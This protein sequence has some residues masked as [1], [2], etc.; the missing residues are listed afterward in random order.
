[1]ISFIVV[2]IIKGLM[3][4]IRV[5]ATCSIS[6]VNS[7]VFLA[8][9]SPLEALASKSS[10]S[11]SFHLTNASLRRAISSSVRGGGVFQRGVFQHCFNSPFE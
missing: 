6:P 10:W 3:H 1:M 4:Q 9:S 2:P 7:A 5:A 8:K 11:R